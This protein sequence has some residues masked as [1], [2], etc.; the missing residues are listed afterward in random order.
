MEIMR[1]PYQ[2]TYLSLIWVYV[3]EILF[4]VGLLDKYIHFQA[5]M[6]L[7]E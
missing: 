2:S 5:H 1:I 3:H 6:R 4:G 7:C